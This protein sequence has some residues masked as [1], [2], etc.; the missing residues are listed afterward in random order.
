MCDSI[1][2]DI[3]NLNVNGPVYDMPTTM[4]KLLYLG[5]S[6][7]DVIL[8]T[9]ANPAKVVNRVE[10]MGQIKVGGPA[11]LAVL[12][13]E[14]GQ[15]R[16]IDSQRNAVSATKRFVSRATIARGRRMRVV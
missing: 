8:R 12:E 6:V 9:T 14:E 3:Y 5:M 2:T 15:F 7:D 1:S 4:S 10:G 16:L 13:L 11:D